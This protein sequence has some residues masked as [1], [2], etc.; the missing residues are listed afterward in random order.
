MTWQAKFIKRL[1]EEDC[2]KKSVRIWRVGKWLNSSHS[3]LVFSSSLYKLSL[4]SVNDIC[5]HC[6]KID[7]G[8][9]S[10]KKHCIF[11]D[12]WQ[13]RLLTYLLGCT[14][15]SKCSQIKPTFLHSMC[16]GEIWSHAKFQVSSFNDL[17][18]PPLFVNQSWHWESHLKW[19]E[20]GT[21]DLAP[22]IGIK[23]ALQNGI[24]LG[25]LAFRKYLK[26]LEENW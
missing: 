20:S 21:F 24:T 10:K 15:F 9:P 22:F 6:S 16:I 17:A 11:Y 23:N 1:N 19:P 14:I 25:V 2:L 7:K 5:H 26:R 12:I 13:I 3:R 8:D 4:S 18:W